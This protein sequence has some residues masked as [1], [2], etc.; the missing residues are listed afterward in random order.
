MN[1]V[2]RPFL[3]TSVG[4]AS[5]VPRTT[6][7]AAAVNESTVGNT[8]EV[9]PSAA[10]PISDPVETTYFFFNAAEAKFIE[11]ACERLIPADE[12]GERLY[13]SGP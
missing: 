9:P 1:K 8:G 6:L 5:A 12:A 2:T 4:A 10:K 13:R 11:A 3:V 7:F